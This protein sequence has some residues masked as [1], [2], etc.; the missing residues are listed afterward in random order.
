MSF[1]HAYRLLHGSSKSD[2]LLS[3]V[4]PVT[5]LV[6]SG[7]LLAATVL[8]VTGWVAS[9]LREQTLSSSEAGLSRLDAVLGETANR[10]LQ[11][12][13]GVLADV[14]IRI[15]FPDISSREEIA[16]WM[17]D[18]GVTAHLDN[19]VEATPQVAA[20]AFIGADGGLIRSSGDW[21]I[22]ETSVA[23]RDY[24]IELQSHRQLDYAI[25]AAYL[26]GAEGTSVIPVARKVRADGGAF[27]GLAVAAVPV[28]DFES[29]FRGVP[30]GY[31]GMIS[32]M[33]RDGGVLA[34]FSPQQDMAVHA[35]TPSTVL[36]ALAGG[37]QGVFEED[38]GEDGE[39]RIYVVQPLAD[40]PLSVVISRS[41]EQAL[42]GW[43]RQAAMFG[44]FA[45]CGVIAIG[46]MVVL[47]ARQ[48]RTHGA[49]AA[50]R[51]EKI[52]AEHARL[53]AEAELLKKAGLSQLL[54]DRE[55]AYEA[56][57]LAKEEAEAANQAK[58]GFLATMSHELRT[59]LNAIIGFSEMMLREVLGALGNEQYRAYVGDIH[60]SGTHLLQ[61]INDILDLSKAE[62]GK[63]E[64][65]EDVFDLRDIMRS[66]GQLTAGRVHDADLSQ[67]VDFAADLPPL[68]GDERKTKQVLLNLI[69]NSV[70]FTPAGGHITVTGRFDPEDGLAVTVAD[71]GI[72]IPEGDLERVLKP[73]EQVDSS[74][75]RQH[76]GTGLGLPL[77]K[78][79]MEMHGG[80]LRLKST[81]GAGTAVTV[82]F[83]PERAILDAD[84]ELPLSV[85]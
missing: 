57:R 53:V 13:K 5:L 67:E 59:P 16:R 46:F 52:E 71:T 36:A 8:I 56:L 3:R 35:P 15:P 84:V 82:V 62:S 24:F 80:R 22:S 1:Q 60:A 54:R 69:A 51:A 79:I 45:V 7:I 40:F 2:G 68:R 70:K 78:A 74:L 29:L 44:A 20:I 81:L 55:A 49:L 21:P 25:G 11:G 58:S 77:V 48:F 41:G 34:Q 66:V 83:P 63:I 64:L 85:A 75:S 4:R 32:L 19:R 17:R 37:A 73:F 50:I 27:A 39:W 61:I 14:T 6:A 38:R 10:S 43:S 31:D 65:S 30:L 9:Y 23:K 12:I 18:P 76:Q 26:G 72:G 33:R 28:A 47:I 42:V